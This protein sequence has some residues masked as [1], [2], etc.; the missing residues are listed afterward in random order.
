MN[1]IWSTISICAKELLP[2]DFNPRKIT[3]EKKAALV[4]SLEKFNLVDIPVANIDIDGRHHLL[5][6][7]KRIEALTILGRGEEFVDVRVPNRMLTEDE[8]KEYMIIANTHAGEFD[9]D[10]LDQHF[11]MLDFDE[12]GFD[13]PDFSVFEPVKHLEGE[14]D[15][16][17]IPEEIQTDIV[18]GDLIEIGPHRLLCGDST[19]PETWERLCQGEKFDLV[20]TDPPYNVDYTGGTAEQLKIMND[21]MSSAAFHAF[22]LDFYSSMG[23]W[24]KEGASW[25]IFHADTEGHN[26]RTAFIQAGNKLAGCLIWVKNSIV[27]G[28]SDYQWKHEPILFGWKLGKPHNWYADRKQS[29]ILNFDRPLRNTEHPTMKPVKLI[30]Y[31]IQNSSLPGDIVGDG[32]LGSGS[33]MVGAEQMNRKC[34][35]TELDPKFCQVIAE[36]MAKAFPYLEIKRNG[37]P[38][39]PNVQ[40]S[41]PGQT[42]TVHSWD[43]SYLPAHSHADGS[44]VS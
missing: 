24:V 19:K 44:P 18:E 21:K 10:L 36:R 11:G 43:P 25:Y 1:L 32:F 35:G 8:A 27:M 9:F 41:H 3:A 30:S 13:L 20:V 39:T 38:W 16:Y 12:I 34:Y 31:L 23:E 5:S 15:D 22:L 26:F 28:R 40:T 37:Q 29:T 6:G 14:E 33:T 17:D 42:D 2:T 4:R 7:H